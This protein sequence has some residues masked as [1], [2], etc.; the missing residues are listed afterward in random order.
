MIY[1][2]G[3]NLNLV[4]GFLLLFFALSSPSICDAQTQ[5]PTPHKNTTTDTAVANTMEVIT[6]AGINAPNMPMLVNVAKT[7][8]AGVNPA[9]MNDW[10]AAAT[11]PVLCQIGRSVS[12][13]GQ[14]EETYRQRH[15]RVRSPGRG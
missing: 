15:P 3:V 10:N 11:D 4:S 1:R 7:P 9:Y 6:A 5:R 14:H 8:P 2:H 13:R 12:L